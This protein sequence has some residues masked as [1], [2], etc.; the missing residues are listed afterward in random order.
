MRKKL[1]ILA[2]L[3][4]S[5]CSLHTAPVAGTGALGAGIGAGTGALIGAAISNGDVASSALLGTAIGLP[6]GLAIGVYRDYNSLESVRER[7]FS[8]IEERQDEIYA[9]QKELDSLRDQIRD[10]GPDGLPTEE[11]REYMYDGAT[12]GRWGR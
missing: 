2:T 8:E 4:V 11:N 7:R 3:V 5:G 6:V 9:R 1:I 12:L 10:D